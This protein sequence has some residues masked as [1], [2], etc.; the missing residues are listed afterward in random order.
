MISRAWSTLALNEIP[1]S[2]RVVR[3]VRVGRVGGGFVIGGGRGYY[4]SSSS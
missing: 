4:E 2:V 1:E 3:V